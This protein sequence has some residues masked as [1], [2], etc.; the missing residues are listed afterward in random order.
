MDGGA[1][2]YLN[3]DEA[4]IPLEDIHEINRQ[5]YENPAVKFTTLEEAS[6]DRTMPKSFLQGG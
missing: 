1:D 3:N 6:L 2:N 4:D 5:M